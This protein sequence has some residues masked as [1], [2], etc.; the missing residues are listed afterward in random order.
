MKRI[1]YITLFYLSFANIGKAQQTVFDSIYYNDI[2]TINEEVEYVYSI[3]K[4]GNGAIGVVLG[5]N[6]FLA[7]RRNFLFKID[8]IGRT[9]KRYYY[10]IHGQYEYNATAIA[11]INDG[12]IMVLGTCPD[13]LNP[14]TNR[15]MVALYNSDLDS[16]DLKLLH[17]PQPR[18]QF[19][20]LLYDGG[21]YVYGT[22]FCDVDA[23]TLGELMAAKFDTLGNLI[24]AN[25]YGLTNRNESG[26]T[27][28]LIGT[29]SLFIG[30]SSN[31]G[32]NGASGLA[33]LLD[34]AGN[35]LWRRYIDIP[36]KENIFGGGYHHK[37]GGYIMPG[38]Y[39]IAP[40]GESELCITKLNSN[41][42]RQWDKFYSL[43]IKS[44]ETAYSF[45]DEKDSTII[46]VGGTLNVPQ[47]HEAG[48]AVK[49]TMEGDTMWTRT[50]DKSYNMNGY[51]DHF[52]KGI[53][54]NDGGYLFAGQTSSG[55]IA[56]KQDA[57]LLKTDSIGC[58]PNY[59]CWPATH[60]NYTGINSTA[61]SN[62]NVYPNPVSNYVCVKFKNIYQNN[63]FTLKLYTVSGQLLKEQTYHY[64]A[65]VVM[66]K[67]EDVPEGMYVLEVKTLY[68]T[69]RVK[70]IKD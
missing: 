1:L 70:L 31:E 18:G 64:A 7:E 20:Q 66:L 23:S 5:T 30:G 68:S 14:D 36:G 19:N 60:Y 40:N 44:E 41:G 25:R 52:Y 57:W 24:W 9:I 32:S 6:V 42:I 63:A 3:T 55:I 59:P 37:D 39:Y 62:F 49:Y 2:N 67:M 8:S 28:Q 4:S 38:T 50:Y 54:T 35:E 61:Y 58:N 29:D 13:S 34:T 16:L 45:Y 12:K 43:G 21:K 65:P 10:P 26:F 47:T 69:E 15:M 17:F 53:A 48:L 22:G 46:G 51:I 56:G 33:V 11:N 27:L